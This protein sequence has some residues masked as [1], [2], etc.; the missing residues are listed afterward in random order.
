[1]K[2]ITANLSIKLISLFLAIIIWVVIMNIINPIINGHI[3]LNVSI[4]NENAILEQNKTYFIIDSKPIRVSYRTQTDNQMAIKQSDFE[5]YIDLNEIAYLGDNSSNE[6]KVAVHVIP[7]SEADS[8]ISN[9]TYEPT[10]LTVLIDDVLRNEY[11]VQYNFKGSVEP[12][13]SIGSVLL[14]PNIVYVSGSNV[15]LENISKIAIDIPVSNSS[16]ETFSGV[17]KVKLYAAD[18]TE[19][20]KE[21]FILSADDINYSVVVNSTASISLNAITVGNVDTGYNLID[22]K[23]EPSIVTIEGPR[24][25]VQNIYTYDLP[26]IN[27]E[28]LTE[29]KEFK[30]KLA[31]V[32]PRGVTSK[33]TEVTVTAV[34]S[35]N[36]INAAHGVKVGPHVENDDTGSESANVIAT[37]NSNEDKETETETATETATKTVESGS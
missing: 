13:H 10:E 18:G 33:T 37:S 34:V 28:G 12:G 14:S 5:T 35:N 22:T 2:K 29:S 27:V 23:V 4:K 31:D 8:K 19:L 7:S 9:M 25:F 26:A 1:M 16:E 15:A 6:R 32:L 24:A 30:F 21:G 20:P 17:S 36:V 11:K 3:N